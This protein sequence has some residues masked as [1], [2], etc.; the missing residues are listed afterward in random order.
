MGLFV[1]KKEEIRGYITSDLKRMVKAVAALHPEREWTMSDVLEEALIG[2][3]AR[4]DN[5]QI[6]KTHHLDALISD[7]D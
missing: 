2:W 4:A 7:Q 6:I 3:L 5:R 1:T